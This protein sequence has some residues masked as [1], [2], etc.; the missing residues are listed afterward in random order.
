[1]QAEELLS[2]TPEKMVKA[3]LERR[4]SMAA[5]LP[6]ALQQRIEENNRA[7]KLAKDAKDAFMTLKSTDNDSSTHQA[8]LK[9]AQNIYDEHESF[10]RRTSSRLQTLKNRIKDCDESIQFWTNMGDGDWGYLLEDANRLASGGDSSYAKSK[11]QPVTEEK[12]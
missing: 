1:M 12:Q 3:I 2:I 6:D 4:Q 7:Y 8:A 9:K 5:S 11:Q 10:R